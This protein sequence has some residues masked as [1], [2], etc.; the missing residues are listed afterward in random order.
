MKVTNQTMLI[1]ISLIVAIVAALAA[2]ALNVL[3]V[4]DKIN[5]LMTQRDGYHSERD[6]ARTDL[7]NAK[8]DLAK[9]QDTLKQTQQELTDTQ[10][11]RDKAVAESQAQTKRANDLSDKLAKTTQE[12]DDARNDLAAFQATGLRPDQIS[13]LN[14]NLKDAQNALEVANEEKSVLQRTVSHL[15]TRL[16]KYEGPETDVKLRA[17][18]KGK[19]LVVD[20]KWDFVVLNVGE[21]QGVLEDGELLVSRDGKLVAKV[22]VRSVQKDRS[23]ANVVPGWQL[24]ELIEGD[25]VT[26]AHPAS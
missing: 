9:T 23:I 19:I 6:Q 2:G 25:E 12:R 8:K 16:A 11:E 20:P 3:Q 10:S 22:V 21:E 17:D 26:P 14:K 1:R 13:G 15:Q 5:T 24:G 7:S 4:R 18:L